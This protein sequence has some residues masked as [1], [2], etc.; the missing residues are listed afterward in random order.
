[1]SSTQFSAKIEM[2][3]SIEKL[4]ASEIVRFTTSAVE[5]LAMKYQ[6]N[7]GEA[8]EHL[9]LAEVEVVR[10]IGGPGTKAKV[11]KEPKEKRGFQFQ[12]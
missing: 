9:G 7:A 2:S 3:R 12:T 1:M 4:M 8:I 11:T 6:F 5:T 10:K